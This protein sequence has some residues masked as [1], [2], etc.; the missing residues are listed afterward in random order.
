MYSRVDAD[1]GNKKEESVHI[2]N[3]DAW[4]VNVY[5]FST[6]VAYVS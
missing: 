3:S 4:V 6:T 2:V 1:N 5:L